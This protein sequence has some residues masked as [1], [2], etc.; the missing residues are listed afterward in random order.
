LRWGHDVDGGLAGKRRHGQNP[1]VAFDISSA[2]FVVYLV[3]GLIIPE[4][5]GNFHAV[6]VA[7]GV[8][9]S[10]DAP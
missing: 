2:I 6:W 3:G 7:Y 5:R 1:D 4:T 8:R 10:D 9:R